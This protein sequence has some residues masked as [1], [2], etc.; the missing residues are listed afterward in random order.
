MSL[1]SIPYE[2]AGKEDLATMITLCPTTRKRP[3]AIKEQKLHSSS[4][5]RIGLFI[6]SLYQILIY[7]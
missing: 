7:K 3:L 1:G 6:I 4:K 2:D 5:I